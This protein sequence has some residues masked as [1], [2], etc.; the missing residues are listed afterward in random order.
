MATSTGSTNRR[1]AC[2]GPVRTTPARLVSDEAECVA[3]AV[4]AVRR[5]DAEEQLLFLHRSGGRMGGRWWPVTGTRDAMET[6]AQCAVREL[7][8]ETGLTPT[9]LFRTAL[10]YPVEGGGYLRIFVAVVTADAGVRLNWEH[11]DYRWCS[12]TQVQPLVGDF[13]VPIMHEAIRIF[14]AQPVALRVEEY[15]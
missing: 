14:R 1:P 5:R 4:Y 6:P 12:Q 8:E 10:T 2:A 7:E 9:A 11:D 15:R 13:V 3:T